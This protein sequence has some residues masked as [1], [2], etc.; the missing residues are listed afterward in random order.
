MLVINDSPIISPSLPQ[1]SNNT[2]LR[3]NTQTQPGGDSRDNSDNRGPLD[4]PLTSRIPATP[5]NGLN[6]ISPLILPGPISP[7]GLTALQKG[8]PGSAP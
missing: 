2:R 6:P 3:I 7:Y 5:S 1:P 8:E 4:T